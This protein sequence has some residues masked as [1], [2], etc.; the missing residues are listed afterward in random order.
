MNIYL[1]RHAKD[2]ERYR[3]GWSQLDLISEGKEQAK[4]LA[5]FLYFKQKEFKITKIISSDLPRALST[6]NE[7]VKKIDVRVEFD[8]E[9]REMN[10]GDLAGM[11]NKEALVKYPGLFFNTLRMDEKYPNGES[12][13]DFYKR[14]KRW[15]DDVICKYKHSNENILIVT[16]GGVINIIC[17]IVKDIEWTNKNKLFKTSD[18]AIYKLNCEGKLEFEIENYNDFL[19]EGYYELL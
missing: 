16:H 12:P 10:N 18:V 11:L 3:G 7:V 8:K 2:D 6:A 5:E 4:K 15:F 19:K 9:L 14:V 1:V 13:D 17:H